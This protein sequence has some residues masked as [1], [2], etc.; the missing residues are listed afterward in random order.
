[1]SNQIW[2]MA[3]DLVRAAVQDGLL[4]EVDYNKERQLVKILYESLQEEYEDFM[5]ENEVKDAA[6]T[7]LS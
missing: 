4:G 6:G 7:S 3:E 5:R 1:M 2:N